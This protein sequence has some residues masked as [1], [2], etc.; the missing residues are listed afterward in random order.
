MKKL[1]CLVLVSALFIAGCKTTIDPVPIDLQA[2]D[3]G[4]YLTDRPQP[5]ISK[6]NKR[7]L[8]LH[9][10]A[11]NDEKSLRVLTGGEVSVHYLVPSIPRKE[12]G[13]PVVI[14]LVPENQEAW[15]AGVSFWR[16]AEKLNQSSVGIEIVNTGYTDEADGTRKWYKYNDA[17]IELLIPLIKDIVKRHNISPYNVV[18]HSDIATQRKVDP[19]PLFPWAKLAQHGIGAWPNTSDVKKYLNGRYMKMP[20][21]VLSVQKLLKQYGYQ[22]PLS[23]ELDSETKNVVKAFQMH[24]RPRDFSGVPDAETEAILRALISKYKL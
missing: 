20:V 6:G 3:R 15:H 7:F 2:R 21:D 1:L 4:N 9:Y 14:H 11:L 24:F 19:G 16:G 17:Q 12:R 8:V 18:G 10:T 13:R 22:V 5:K 23:G